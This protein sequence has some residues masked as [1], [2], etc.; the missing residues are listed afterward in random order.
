MK[1]QLRISQ[2]QLCLAR[3]QKI[4]SNMTDVLKEKDRAIVVTESSA[5]FRIMHVNSAWEGLCGWTREESYGK[6]LSLLQG[7]ETDV[8]AVTSLINSL[9]QGE[10]AGIVVTNYTKEGRRFRNHLRVGPMD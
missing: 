2:N 4:P 10:Q 8:C 5:P 9:L 1:K 3:H 7:R 6:T